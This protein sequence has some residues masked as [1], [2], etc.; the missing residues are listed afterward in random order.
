[1]YKYIYDG[2][3]KEFNKVITEKWKGETM[4]VSEKRARTNLAFQ[5]KREFGKSVNSKISFPGK[6]MSVD[7]EGWTYD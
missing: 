2:P 5:F 3:V 4:A 7:M 6:I 1:M